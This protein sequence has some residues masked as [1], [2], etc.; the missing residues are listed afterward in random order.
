MLHAM[1][2]VLLV[3][4]FVCVSTPAFA[5]EL[6][7]MTQTPDGVAVY[8][9]LK[10]VKQVR[11]RVNGPVT[12]A[13]VWAIIDA[14]KGIPGTKAHS[15][16][17][18]LQFDCQ[19]DRSREAAEYLYSGQMGK[20]TILK[21][22]DE[23]TTARDPLVPVSPGPTKIL[24]DN[25]C[26]KDMS[27]AFGSLFS[28]V[29]EAEEKETKARQAL[30][31]GWHEIRPRSGG[32]QFF[33]DMDSFG[34]IDVW[35]PSCAYEGQ[36]ESGALVDGYSVEV[37]QDFTA[38]MT[39][40]NGT[41]YYSYRFTVLQ[42]QNFEKIRVVNQRAYTGHMGKGTLLGKAPD[43]EWMDVGRDAD[44]AITDVPT[45][46]SKMMNKDSEFL[47]TRAETTGHD[48][49]TDEAHREAYRLSIVNAKKDK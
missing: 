33:I 17:T 45:I 29:A 8:M 6:L 30:Y 7:L 49:R 39:T 5:E 1:K 10:S 40:G 25:A 42:D 2:H 38:P 13:S 9:D 16:K 18:K 12:E 26:A 31:K 19:G 43:E 15:V 48:Q 37:I 21:A 11:Q 22:K 27:V 24:L 28:G 46:L 14:P 32:V 3:T 47:M 23:R 34:L 20:G 41:Q 35:C 36:G 44:S 4:A